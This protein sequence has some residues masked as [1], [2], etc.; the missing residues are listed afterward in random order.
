MHEPP[1]SDGTDVEYEITRADSVLGYGGV[2]LG[3][4]GGLRVIP[5]HQALTAAIPRWVELPAHQADTVDA[6]LAFAAH[7][8]PAVRAACV[9]ALGDLARRYG[10]VAQRERVVRAIELGLRDRDKDVRGVATQSADILEQA[11]GWQISRPV[12]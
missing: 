10:R 3:D 8:H 7:E 1:D 9:V 4:D 5:E 6:C 2:V 12:V 11:L